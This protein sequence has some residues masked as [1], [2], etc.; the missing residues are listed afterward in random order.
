MS[1]PSSPTNNPVQAPIN[2][3]I[4]QQQLN[5]FLGP[6]NGALGGLP[7]AERNQSYF[8]VFQQ[9]GGTGP[10][11]IDQTAFFITYLVDENGNVS[12]PSEDYDSLN[13][14]IQNFEVGKNAVVRNDASTAIN[15]NLTGRKQITAIGRQ[16]PIL[17]SQTGSSAGANVDSISFSSGLNQDNV[18]RFLFWLNKGE[19]SLNPGNNNIGSYNSPNQEPESSVASVNASTGEYIV[20]TLSGDGGNIQNIWFSVNA[21]FENYNNDSVGSINGSIQLLKDGSYYDSFPFSVP[22]T[23]TLGTPSVEDFASGFYVSKA[24]LN[25]STFKVRIVVDDPNLPYAFKIAYINFKSVTQNPNTTAPPTNLPFWSNNS[26]DN[27]WVTAS[28]EISL[29]YGNTQNSE[30]VLAESGNDYNLSPIE[31]RFEVIAGDRIRFEYNPQTEYI[32]YEVIT[33]ANDTQGRLKLRLNTL[34]PSSVN[35]DNFVLHRVNVNDPSYI[36]LN[37][38]KNASNGNTQNFNGVI[39]PEY[40][41]KRLKNNLDNIILELKQSGIITD[42]EN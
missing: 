17:Y 34:V 39:L 40:P 24:D 22:P 42:N 41:T 30:N 33:P 5:N 18:P 9:A 21:R 4:E 26:G 28:N 7:V 16:Q 29:N 2:N 19:A 6:V 10:E 3:S 25:S 27:L 35:L 1:G 38:K 15:G 32:I 13:N 23:S 20:T 31:S 14:L 37:V 12:K 11:I 8:I 36:I